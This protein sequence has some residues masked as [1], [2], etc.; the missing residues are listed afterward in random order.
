MFDVGSRLGL[1]NVHLQDA[2]TLGR[3]LAL[4]ELLILLAWMVGVLVVRGGYVLLVG[5]GL[6]GGF[7]L[8]LGGAGVVAVPLVSRVEC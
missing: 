6:L 1:L 7:S 2:F 8:G 5:L 4:D 3:L